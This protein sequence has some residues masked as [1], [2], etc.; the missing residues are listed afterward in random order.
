MVELV[1]LVM[2]VASSA[3][4]DWR[5]EKGAVVMVRSRL[6]LRTA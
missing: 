6:V 5:E 3:V 4:E 1:A 2:K